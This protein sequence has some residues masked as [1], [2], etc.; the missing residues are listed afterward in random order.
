MPFRSMEQGIK[1]VQEGKLEEGARLLRIALRDETL[2]GKLRAVAL[3]WLAETSTDPDHKTRCYKE[4][5]EADPGNADVTQRMAYL[6]SSQLPPKQTPLPP[7]TGTGTAPIQGQSAPPAQYP[8][9]YGQQQPM[10]GQTPAYGQPPATGQLSPYNQPAVSGQTPSYGQQSGANYGSA[11]YGSAVF[12]RTVGVIGGPNGTGTAFFVSQNG[13]LATTRYVVGGVENV[14]IALDN[15]RN[16]PGRVIR[17]FP[18]FD[19]ALIQVDLAASNLLPISPMPHVP[20]NARITAISNNGKV[21]TGQCRA[22][23]RRLPPQWFPTTINRVADAG[24][25]PVFDDSNYLIGMLTR[26]MSRSS[27]YVYGLHVSALYK[28][29]ETYNQE[30]AADANRVYCPSC[31]HNSRAISVGA[32]YCE[33]CGSVLP[34]ARQVTRFPLPQTAAFYGEN[35][36]QPCPHCGARLGYYDGKCLRCG[37]T[38][39]TDPRNPRNTGRRR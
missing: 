28:C 6:L 5:L 39:V 18:E 29:L 31:G 26:N 12:F 37:G 35:M 11:N 23:K 2:V 16:V 15:G 17:A 19:L 1:A 21:M 20:E 33:V 34:Q 3:T 38:L 30:M 25:D 36:Y 10:T 13:L 4:A 9:A 7:Q 8:P 24:G 22:T 32:F 27:S 14:T